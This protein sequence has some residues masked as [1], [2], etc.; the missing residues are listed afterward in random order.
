MYFN[1]RLIPRLNTFFL[2]GCLSLIDSLQVSVGPGDLQ[3]RLSHLTL[4][5]FNNS[6]YLLQYC[7]RT[8]WLWYETRQWLVRVMGTQVVGHLVLDNWVLWSLLV[9]QWFQT[10]VRLMMGHMWLFLALRGNKDWAT[11]RLGLF[12]GHWS[13]VGTTGYCLSGLDFQI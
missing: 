2:Q 7:G 10:W 8:L 1:F 5:S 13:C 12:V 9:L 3:E 4:D 11:H 6:L